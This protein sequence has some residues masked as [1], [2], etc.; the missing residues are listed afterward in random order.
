MSDDIA[1][2]TTPNPTGALVPIA[3]PI[4]NPEDPG[5]PPQPQLP[6]VLPPPV[7]V[8]PHLCIINLPEGCYRITHTPAGQLG[9]YQ[10]TL[11]VD[12]AGGKTVVSGDLYWRPP[13]LLPPHGPVQPP[14]PTFPKLF[15]IP[16]YARNRYHSYLKVT[17]IKT[18]PVFGGGPCQ[19]TL[20]V[21]QYNYTQPPAGSFNGTFP[22]VP[23]RTVS[24]V[25]KPQAAPA[26]FGGSYF[27]GSLFEG[28]VDKGAF[29]MGWVSKFFRTA[30]I[31]IDTLTGSVAPQAVP[32]LSGG[33]TEDIK[34]TFATAGWDVNV[35]YDQTNVPVPAGVTATACWSDADLHALMVSVRKPTTNLDTEWHLHVLVVP[36]QLG[37]GRG[38]MYDQIGV[39]REGVAIF[40][41][42]G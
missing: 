36:A 32:A 29:T 21:E 27:G 19:L 16:I 40:S 4:P 38:V 33:G 13:F 10:G 23:S 11:R 31:E 26:G 2:H 15:G 5:H 24:L 37:C 20:T 3:G 25:L 9:I 35:K 34:S 8:P 22:A 6:P 41:D 17:G 18:S 39:P 14:F 42:D 30:N 1:D 7:P 12:K 28:G